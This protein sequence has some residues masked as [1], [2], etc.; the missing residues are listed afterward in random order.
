MDTTSLSLCYASNSNPTPQVPIYLLQISTVFPPLWV[1]S[2]TVTTAP[3]TTHSCPH[4][5][6]CCSQ[7]PCRFPAHYHT[8]VCRE[9]IC[10]GRGHILSLSE[11]GPNL[12]YKRFSRRFDCSF[13]IVCATH[14][15]TCHWAWLLRV[16]FNF[17][18]QAVNVTSVMINLLPLL[19][20]TLNRAVFI[21]RR[22]P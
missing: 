3:H 10:R 16:Q 1:L 18:W 19:C 14:S 7:T 4:Y 6:H 12:S 17:K 5:C 15:A 2:P 11:R 21:R 8:Q 9:V 13:F 22:L 20:I